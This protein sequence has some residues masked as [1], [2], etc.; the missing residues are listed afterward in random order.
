MIGGD[1]SITK[2]LE[3]AIAE[4]VKQP[5]EVQDAMASRLKEDLSGE[6]WWEQQF[7]ATTDEERSRIVEEAR[8]EIA[9][10]ATRRVCDRVLDRFS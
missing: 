10:R 3:Q 9:R 5:P 8:T 1:G 4:I 7:A 2:W 6:M